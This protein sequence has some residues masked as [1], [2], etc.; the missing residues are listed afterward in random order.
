MDGG[1][2]PVAGLDIL[3]APAVSWFDRNIIAHWSEVHIIAWVCVVSTRHIFF[4]FQNYGHRI[5][6]TRF[7]AH[8]PRRTR[9]EPRQGGGA[10]RQGSWRLPSPPSSTP[11]L[12]AGGVVMDNP[13]PRRTEPVIV[14]VG[15]VS[16][17]ANFILLFLIFRFTIQ[18]LFVCHL[19]TVCYNCLRI[20]SS[21]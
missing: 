3:L 11:C 12:P 13:F 19:M 7:S 8:R 2:R 16:F 18:V 17:P 20:C 5:A 4:W 9:R 1:I 10:L 15:G 14:N 21:Q 6:D